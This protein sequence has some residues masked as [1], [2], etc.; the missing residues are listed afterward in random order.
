MKFRVGDVIVY[1]HE[2]PPRFY[3]KVVE[4]IMNKRYRLSYKSSAGKVTVTYHKNHVEKWFKR[5]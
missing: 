2:N 1:S 5:V 4:M 3:Y